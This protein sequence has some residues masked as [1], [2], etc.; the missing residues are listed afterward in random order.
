MRAPGV[1]VTC[2]GN[3]CRA[4]G[5]ADEAG[6][7][8]YWTRAEVTRNDKRGWTGATREVDLCETCAEKLAAML[9][10]AS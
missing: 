4:K 2:D 9:G 6:G 10:D 5:W 1:R 7:V 8:P 3:G